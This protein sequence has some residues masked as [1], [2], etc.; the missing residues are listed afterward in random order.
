MIGILSMREQSV[1]QLLLS[2]P[3]Q[4]LLKYFPLNII[5]F[6][7]FCNELSMVHVV[8]DHW[9]NRQ[10][11]AIIW[12]SDHQRIYTWYT[13][14]DSKC[15]I[16]YGSWINILLL[17]FYGPDEFASGAGFFLLASE[18]PETI[19]GGAFSISRGYFCGVL[20]AMNYYRFRLCLVFNQ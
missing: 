15:S 12:T 17:Q 8:A 5:L 3:R 14:K 6:G 16:F 19:I 2:N 9:L 7:L 1:L 18:Q 10:Q 11:V 4:A 13:S 20:M